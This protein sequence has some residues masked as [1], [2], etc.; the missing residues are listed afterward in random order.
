MDRER[1][2]CRSSRHFTAPPSSISQQTP[3]HICSLC[4]KHRS[5]RYRKL[6]P[7]V[8]GQ[9][10]E[11][12]ICSRPTCAEAVNELLLILPCQVNLYEIHHHH[13]YNSSAGLEGPPPSYTATEVR[14]PD[15]TPHWTRHSSRD[16]S[17]IRE[18]STPINT[19]SKPEGPPPNCTAAEL[20][21]ES[22]MTGRVELPDNGLCSRRHPFRRLSPILKKSPPAVNFLNKPTLEKKM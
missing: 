22:S 5:S 7:L 9:A 15:N 6:H 8:P 16:L 14:L 19:S 18:E 17:P 10:P 12:G 13:H 20:S 21:G 11:P 4:G 1:R 2:P 3:E